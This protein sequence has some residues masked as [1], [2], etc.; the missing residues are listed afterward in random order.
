[1]EGFDRIVLKWHLD[2]IIY[3]GISVGPKIINMIVNTLH[4]T[5]L[6]VCTGK[7]F[8]RNFTR[9]QLLLQLQHNKMIDQSHNEVFKRYALHN[10]TQ[11]M[12]FYWTDINNI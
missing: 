5:T 10:N 9:Y 7:L 8:Y 2:N 6:Y 4:K 12:L 3:K 11:I 1:M